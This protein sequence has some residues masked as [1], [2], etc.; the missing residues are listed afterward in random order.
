M[1]NF[2]KILPV[3]AELFHVDRQID[4]STPTDLTNLI[5]AFRKICESALK[6]VKEDQVPG[7]EV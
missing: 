2:M 6:K 4:G 1:S 3:E 5:V 7:L